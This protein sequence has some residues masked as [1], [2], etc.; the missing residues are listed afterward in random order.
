MKYKNI[1]LSTLFLSTTIA[2]VNFS[3]ERRKMS[4][5]QLP[6]AA[7]PVPSQLPQHTAQTEQPKSDLSKK[8]QAE[9]IEMLAR[10]TVSK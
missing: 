9:L 4:P 1:F 10:L 7:Y 8:E 5:L 6:A 2:Q 3:S